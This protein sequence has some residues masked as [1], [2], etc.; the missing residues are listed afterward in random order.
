[1]NFT[2]SS[3]KINDEIKTVG[4]RLQLVE[5]S[6]IFQQLHLMELMRWPVTPLKF[7]YK[8]YKGI[9]AIRTVV[10]K[11]IWLGKTDFHPIEQFFLQALDLDK[12]EMRDF[13]IN[14]ILN[15]EN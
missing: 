14:D 2:K 6:K 7:S 13:A 5:S 8:N 12:Q 15:F 3:I 1:M 4:G 9:I 10:P 11:L